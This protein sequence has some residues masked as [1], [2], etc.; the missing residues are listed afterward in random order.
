MQAE[1]SNQLNLNKKTPATRPAKEGATQY[2]ENLKKQIPTTVTFPTHRPRGGA[3]SAVISKT[4]EFCQKFTSDGKY[5]YRTALALLRL[6]DG[7]PNL[8]W[9]GGHAN[10]HFD[11]CLPN[12]GFKQ[13]TQQIVGQLLDGD[14]DHR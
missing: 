9:P 2:G 12:T 3:V 7:C 10:F 5:F 4:P 13:L 6:P 8:A 14:I 11:Q 1:S